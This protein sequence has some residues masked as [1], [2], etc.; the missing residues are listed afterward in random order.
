VDDAI[1]ISQSRCLQ[2]CDAQWGTTVQPRQGRVKLA[3]QELPG[4]QKDERQSRQ[5]R[6]IALISAVPA[7]TRSLSFFTRQFLPGYFQ[8]RLPALS[9]GSQKILGA[10]SMFPR[11]GLLTI[12]G[13][14]F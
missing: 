1:E 9:P 11:E 4:K 14:S 5:G 2:H 3:R 6:L 12:K 13:V 8:P 10:D 7:G